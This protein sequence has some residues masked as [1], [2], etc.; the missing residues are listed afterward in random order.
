MSHQAVASPHIHSKMT[1]ST[2]THG[3]KWT[4]ACR[5]PDNCFRTRYVTVHSC[6][7]ARVDRSGPNLDVCFWSTDVTV[8]GSKRRSTRAPGHEWT[9]ACQIWT[10]ASGAQTS[11]STRAQGHEWTGACQVPDNCFRSTQDMPHAQGVTTRDLKD[12]LGPSPEPYC[13]SE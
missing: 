5:V 3:H 13:R 9:G 4:G 1:Q 10:S 7:R 6:P 11:Q 8:E 2:G 12:R